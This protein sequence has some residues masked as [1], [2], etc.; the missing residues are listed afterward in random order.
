MIN[1]L[2]TRPQT[3]SQ[4]N[5]SRRYRSPSTIEGNSPQDDRVRLEW[6]RIWNHVCEP[7]AVLDN[8]DETMAIDNQLLAFQ[9]KQARLANFNNLPE[10]GVEEIKRNLEQTMQPPTPTANHL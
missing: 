9:T 8:A 5:F 10:N 2:A 3:R 1:P 6:E 7:K 4:T